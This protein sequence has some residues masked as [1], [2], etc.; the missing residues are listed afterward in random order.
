MLL[1]LTEAAFRQ[2]K[3][4]E[5]QKGQTP[6]IE[7]DITGGCGISIKFTLVIDEPRR[8]DI[9]LKYEGFQIHIDQFTKRSLNE[10]IQIDY[11]DKEGFLVGESFTSNTCAFKFN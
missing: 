9:I 4:M 11:R 3:T 6:R 8:N 1:K 5:L 7:A 2:L 10:E